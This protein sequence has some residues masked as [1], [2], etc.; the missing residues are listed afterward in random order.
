M[1]MWC[2]GKEDPAA[3]ATRRR[4]EI[5]S[6]R[7]VAWLK[8]VWPIDD[9]NK[10]L[11]VI[12]RSVVAELMQRDTR[13]YNI[14]PNGDITKPDPDG[15]PQRWIGDKD[16]ALKKHNGRDAT[17]ETK[18][19]WRAWCGLFPDPR[20]L[21]SWISAIEED[22]GTD[23]LGEPLCQDH[24]GQRPTRLEQS[25]RPDLEYHTGFTDA[26]PRWIRDAPA[27]WCLPAPDW[28][29]KQRT[30]AEVEKDQTANKE[31]PTT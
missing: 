21:A 20:Y 30:T 13:L 7:C 2:D 27:S 31:V 18:R 5:E 9:R 19:R 10:V 22:N 23:D 17:I 12:S 16:L 15:P 4:E 8:S 1:R 14:R 29:V 6:E 11:Y 26:L 25:K 28:Y 3:R 24:G